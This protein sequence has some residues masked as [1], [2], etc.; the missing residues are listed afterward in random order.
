[1]KGRYF[2]DNRIVRYLPGTGRSSK[3]SIYSKGDSVLADKIRNST[4]IKRGN[5]LYMVQNITGYHVGARS[6]GAMLQVTARAGY[7]QDVRDIWIFMRNNKMLQTS[8]YNYLLELCIFLKQYKV[9]NR[10]ISIMESRNVEKDTVTLVFILKAL[11]FQS[12]ACIVDGRFKEADEIYLEASKAFH[13]ISSN[14]IIGKQSYT[15]LLKC[16]SRAKHIVNITADMD[17]KGLLDAIFFG[18]ALSKLAVLKDS[19]DVLL[20]IVDEMHR[21]MFLDNTAR[22]TV[23]KFY[24]VRFDLDGLSKFIK[25]AWQRNPKKLELDHL[26]GILKTCTP[27]AA[28]GFPEAKKL[29]NFICDIGKRKSIHL[30]GSDYFLAAASFF[31]AIG[32]KENLLQIQAS[33]PGTH[34]VNLEVQGIGWGSKLAILAKHHKDTL[35]IV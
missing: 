1:M 29:G 23:L 17:K 32:D 33:R 7:I 14:N 2:P 5:A 26:I 15:L 35:K 3:D 16:A 10:V 18:A 20:M 25:N 34:Y 8:S 13:E 4:S 22:D 12:N 27:H 11:S 19:D 31:S 24:E 21:R 28:F 6:Y 9:L 30:T